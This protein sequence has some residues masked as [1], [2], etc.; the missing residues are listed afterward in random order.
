[1]GNVDETLLCIRD[2]FLDIMKE[3]V[4][5]TEFNII[6]LDQRTVNFVIDKSLTTAPKALLVDH[7]KVFI[8]S[9]EITKVR[10]DAIVCSN[11]AK[12]SCLTRD[13][14]CIADL[15]GNEYRKQCRLVS[16]A[17]D[18]QPSDVVSISTKNVGVVLNAV[19]PHLTKSFWKFTKFDDY[20][21]MQVL[22]ITIM[23]V[24]DEACKRGVSYL[25]MP[26]LSAG[27]LCICCNRF[28]SFNHICIVASDTNNKLFN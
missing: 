9:G 3:P 7:I 24:I 28:T 25:A 21:Y 19:V 23:N 26:L 4:P 15:A 16:E 17:K 27:K 11:D 22:Y 14:K 10:A 6:E 5:K 18:L 13:A 1:V 12:L 8:Y 2:G 20:V